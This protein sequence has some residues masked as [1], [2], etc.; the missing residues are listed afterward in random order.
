M[1]ERVEGLGVTFAVLI[2]QDSGWLT[3]AMQ[4]SLISVHAICT[5]LSN[6]RSHDH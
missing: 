2:M 4:E 6:A 3:T 5:T 1:L